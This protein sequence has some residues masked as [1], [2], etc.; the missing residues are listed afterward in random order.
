MRL[1]SV[2]SRQGASGGTI[3]LDERLGRFPVALL[4]TY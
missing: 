2:F 1:E 3:D 4:T